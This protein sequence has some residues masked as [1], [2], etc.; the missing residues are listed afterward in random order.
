[1]YECR[2]VPDIVI[3]LQIQKRRVV[4][5]LYK[6][7]ETKAKFDKLVEERNKAKQEAKEKR[8]K[9]REEEKKKKMQE[10]GEN[11]V[12]EPVQEDEE[13]EDTT[14]A[15]D[16]PK[17]QAEKKDA[18]NATYDA[19]FQAI[20][21]LG[22]SMSEK[23]ISVIPIKADGNIE[24]THKKIRSILKNYLE[25]REYLYERSLPYDLKPAE[26]P[27]NEKV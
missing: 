12:E 23:R 2:R 5:R 22:K 13:P 25:E 6:D 7:E 4:E 20:E 3:S 8:K 27:F 1:M 26:V 14:E 24:T 10:M 19:D 18:L 16:L 17:M 11:Y 9:D 21:D 15:P